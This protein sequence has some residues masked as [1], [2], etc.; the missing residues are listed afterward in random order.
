MRK[1]RWTS[2]IWCPTFNFFV[3][4]EN[5]FSL[6]RRRKKDSDGFINMKR[7]RWLSM[8]P[9]QPQFS[10]SNESSW[11][12]CHFR[13]Q[14]L[15]ANQLL[16][17]VRRARKYHS[18]FI[19]LKPMKPFQDRRARS[20]LA[21]SIFNPC[22]EYSTWSYWARSARFPTRL[23]ANFSAQKWHVYIYSIFFFCGEIPDVVV[24]TS[25]RLVLKQRY[26]YN[27]VLILRTYQKWKLN[28]VKKNLND[29]LQ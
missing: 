7:N 28:G 14:N 15:G 4:E 13:K 25:S 16:L 6:V 9:G 27:K 3:T 19:N 18:F 1:K 24:K 5:I 21:I 23:F 12:Y 2:W 20:T 8:F 11:R 29:V 17:V 10:S 26:I 22:Q